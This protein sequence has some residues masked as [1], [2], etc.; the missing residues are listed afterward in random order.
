MA[1]RGERRRRARRCAVASWPAR[2]RPR[3]TSA[4]ARSA[5]ARRERS[6]P[7]TSASGA[8]RARRP[9]RPPDRRRRRWRSSA[10][11]SSSTARASASGSEGERLGAHDRQ[12]LGVAG[13]VGLEAGDD[14]GV[15][16]LAAVALERPAA[17]GDDGGEAAGPL[18]QLLDGDERSLTSSAPRAVSSAPAVV[19]LG[20]ERASSA[21][22]A[23]SRPA[24]SSLAPASAVE[25]GAQ[26]GDLAAG[27]VDAQRGQ[28]A[29]QLAVA[30][31]GLGL[32]LERA[33]LAAHLAQ[34]VLDAQQVG[35][36]GVEA[37]LGLLLA[38]AVLE[39][40]GGLLDDRP[41]L[42]GAG[43]EHGVDLALADDDVLL[44]ADAGVGQQLLHVEQPARHVVDGVLAVAG[45]E[46]RAPDGDL[47][48]LDRQDAGRV[49]DREADLGPAERRAR[50]G[51]GEDDVVHLLAAH[52][53]RRLRAEHPGD[54]VDDV[55]LAR[56]VGPDDDG[57]AR[58]ELQ[59]R[60]LGERLEALEGQALQEHGASEPTGP[61]PPR[62]GIPDP[63]VSCTGCLARHVARQTP[64][65][66]EHSDGLG[67]VGTTGSSGWSGR[68][69]RC[70]G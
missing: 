59:R 60:R 64:G 1:Q 41:A 6:S 35:L 18:A 20:V 43:V 56:A 19:D 54:G 11:R 42:L 15:E 10:K 3:S 36:G 50:G 9:A 30:A 62:S 44:A 37:A 7:R 23:A 49:V 45:A 4:S 40:A 55:R 34:Q 38:L 28:L 33:Q 67:G 68:R 58:F 13:G 2:S 47:G 14:A 70:G 31:G 27:D 51:A 48:E 52:G 46:Q 66:H 57:D 32:A 22:S 5:D 12:L 61:T 39:D 53:A 8:G 25:A 65:Q 21:F 26:A 63:S 69:R 24:K 29:D 16:E 17:L